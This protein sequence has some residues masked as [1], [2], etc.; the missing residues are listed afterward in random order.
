MTLMSQ[1][2][3]NSNKIYFAFNYIINRIGK[4]IT[5]KS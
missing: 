3:F 2:T 4:K 1:G 5:G